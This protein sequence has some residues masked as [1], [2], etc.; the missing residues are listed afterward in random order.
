M[1]VVVVRYETTTTARW[2][3]LFVV[4]AF[5]NDTVTIAVRTGFHAQVCYFVH[6][7]SSACI[8]ALISGPTSDSGSTF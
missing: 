6:N 4:C 1:V 3:L 7:L 2:A 5:F 8:L